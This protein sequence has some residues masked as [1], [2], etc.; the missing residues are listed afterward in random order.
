[1]AMP[2][3]APRDTLADL[4]RFVRDVLPWRVPTLEREVEIS[5]TEVFAG[6]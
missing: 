4:E 3:R 1:M 5:L 2:V 6:L